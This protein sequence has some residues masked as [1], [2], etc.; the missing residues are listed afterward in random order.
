MLL[1]DQIAQEKEFDSLME[2][3]L[4]RAAKLREKARLIREEREREKREFVNEKL[5]MKWR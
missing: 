5:D 3:P 2:S 4:E 1:N